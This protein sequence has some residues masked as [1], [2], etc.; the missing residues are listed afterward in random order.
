MLK[1]Y[2][3]RGLALFEWYEGAKM[4]EDDTGP[5]DLEEAYD[6]LLVEI[7][8]QREDKGAEFNQALQNAYIFYTQEHKKK[9]NE[10]E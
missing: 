7:Q 9:E 2:G 8:I 5:F 6:R 10:D 1:E 3:I 4:F